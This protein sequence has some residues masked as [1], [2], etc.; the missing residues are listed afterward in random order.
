MRAAAFHDHELA[1]RGGSRHRGDDPLPRGGMAADFDVA[2]EQLRDLT[3]P[4]HPQQAHAS[5]G[6]V[7]NEEVVAD[8][9]DVAADLAEVDRLAIRDPTRTGLVEKPQ[10]N[11]GSDEVDAGRPRVGREDRDDPVRGDRGVREREV[12]AHPDQLSL[13]RSVGAHGDQSRSQIP[14]IVLDLVDDGEHLLAAEHHSRMGCRTRGQRACLVSD[15][16]LL[17]RGLALRAHRCGGLVERLVVDRRHRHDEQMGGSVRDVPESIGVPPDAGDAASRLGRGFQPLD[18]PIAALLGNACGEGQRRA[19]FGPVEA[20]DAEWGVGDLHRLPSPGTHHV[21]LPLALGVA[22][23][24]GDPR[25]VRRQPRSG[26]GGAAGEPARDAA[27]EL[28]APH[29]P[30]RSIRGEIGPRR[31]EDRE[32]AIRC[33]VRAADGD[34]LL[35]IGCA[36]P[37]SPANEL[38]S[39]ISRVLSSGIGSTAA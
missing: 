19:V 22:T 36:H 37:H 18:A 5:T 12:R 30:H 24:E 1:V 23:H 34:E 29:L 4:R 32:R 21:D 39:P 7:L 15:Q 31:R 20:L 14:P 35:D 9:G 25:R 10:R 3:G 16:L 11:T 33:D 8:S 38:V 17:R 27:G 2:S 6:A 28:D 13:A 26:V